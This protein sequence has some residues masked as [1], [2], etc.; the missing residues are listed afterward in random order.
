MNL[1]K[2]FGTIAIQN[3]EALE[4]IDETTQAGDKASSK[5]SG[6]F[7]KIGSAAVACGKVIATGL[8]AGAAAFGALTVK[9]LNAAGELEQNMGGS[10]AVFGKY[11][12]NMQKTA[13]NAFSSM[14]LSASDFL[15]TANKMGSLFKGAGFDVEEA[16]ELTATAMQRAADVASIMGLDVSVAM[17]SIA[18]AAKGNFTM[19]DNLGV[20]MNDT[21]LQAYAYAQGIE[22]AT[23]DMTN[24]EKIGLAMQMFLEKTADYAGNYAKENETLAGSLTTAKAALGNFLSGVGDASTLGDTLISTGNV[25]ATKLTE[26]LPNLVKGITNLLNQLIPH[27]PPL[28]EQVLPGVI[29][30]AVALLKGLV[31]ALPGLVKNVVSSLFKALGSDLSNELGNTVGNAVESVIGAV[32]KIISGIGSVIGEFLPIIIEVVD[33]IVGVIDMLSSNESLGEGLKKVISSIKGLLENV[34]PIIRGIAEKILPALADILGIILQVAAPVID[35]LGEI[36]GWIGDVLGISVEFTEAAYIMTEAEKEIAEQAE[37]ARKKHK[38]LMDEFSGEAQT[39]ED[40]AK[41]TKELWEELKNCVDA[42]GNVLKGYEDRAE[43]ITGELQRVAGLELEIVDGQVK[44]Y[45]TLA[46]EIDNVIA[47]QQAQRLLSAIGDD[48]DLAKANVD[49]YFSDFHTKDQAY[50][51]EAERTASYENESDLYYRAYI[52]KAYAPSR[53]QGYWDWIEEYEAQVQREAAALEARNEAENSYLEAMKIIS[54]YET[55]YG[56]LAVGNYQAAIDSLNEWIGTLDYYRE[57]SSELTEE[58]IA[59]LQDMYDKAEAKRSY[60]WDQLMAGTEGFTA[61]EYNEI[62]TLCN[63]MQG[64]LMDA[65]NGVSEGAEEAG[66]NVADGFVA[67][68]E[69]RRPSVITTAGGIAAAALTAMQT[70]AEIRSPSRVT[71]GFGRYIME[72]LALGIED[73]ADL[74]IKAAEEATS[75]ALDA[76]STEASTISMGFDP[77]NVPSVDHVISGAVDTKQELRSLIESLPD[78]ITYAISNGLSLNIN[79]RE[80]ARMVKAVT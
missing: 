5:L 32:S 15:G 20:A 25:I 1:F 27:I 24:Q 30:G 80:F 65:L 44:G 51:A 60:Y 29:Q 49:T 64:M 43:F 23:K 57:K 59:N 62:Q 35:V 73:E 10:E 16:S 54:R 48:Y 38:E 11:A 63:E 7:S 26:L 56:H 42:N 28:I 66:E 17:E 9:A 76:M 75:N 13:E 74:A 22:K 53:D 47:K 39:I 6:A 45:Q 8:A 50:D 77:S 37:N 40:E 21:T 52:G 55:A 41:R 58:E 31:K 61:E 33:I 67:G 70:T 72:G 19:M 71:R 3:K 14:G 36:I 2:L 46:A 78:L 68:M 18:G 69:S 4:G 79:N 34:V 12:Q